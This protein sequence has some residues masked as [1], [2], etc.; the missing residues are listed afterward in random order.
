MIDYY[1]TTIQ[2]ANQPQ[3]Q[4]GGGRPWHYFCAIID[5][6]QPFNIKKKAEAVIFQTNEE[7]I[8]AV[9]SDYYGQR[10]LDFVEGRCV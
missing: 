6:L 1:N 10:I 4:K 2:H 9:P 5:I 3:D 8:S 7:E